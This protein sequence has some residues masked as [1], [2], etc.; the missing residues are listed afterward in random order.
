MCIH[1]IF[2][3][4]SCGAFKL[5]VGAYCHPGI[6]YTD[7]P[8]KSISVSHWYLIPWSFFCPYIILFH[9]ATCC[10]WYTRMFSSICKKVI[11]NWYDMQVRN[12]IWKN[13]WDNFLFHRFRLKWSVLFQMYQKRLFKS[14]Y[15]VPMISIVF[16][17]E[18]GWELFLCRMVA[19]LFRCAYSDLL[20]YVCFHIL[21]W[22]TYFR[23]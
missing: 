4:M 11:Y 7:K 3:L 13:M 23:C 10:A 19:N 2:A 22:F 15:C 12:V 16:L 14:L 1:P 5:T 20:Q 21:F 18:R 6:S 17:E 9:W 8:W